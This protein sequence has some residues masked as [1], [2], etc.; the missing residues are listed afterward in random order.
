MVTKPGGYTAGPE[1]PT[2]TLC[3]LELLWVQRVV[4]PLV[5]VSAHVVPAAG[6]R[7][8]LWPSW[9]LC[10]RWAFKVVNVP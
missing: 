7:G 3:A 2:H 9:S 1:P 8:C 4:T 5:K 10:K 6:S